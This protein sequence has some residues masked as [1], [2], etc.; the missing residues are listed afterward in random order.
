M[1]IGK[2]SKRV[3]LTGAGWSHNWGARLAAGV[4]QLILDFPDVRN[5]DR[6]SALLRDEQSFE[7][8]LART[9]SPPFVEADH[10]S[11]QRAL[12]EAFISMDRAIASPPNP[13]INIYQVQDL[14]FRFWGQR[15]H[16]VDT[17][18]L[19]TLNQ[20]LFFERYLYNN[21]VY[22]APPPV[23]PAVQ[24]SPGQR[25]FT[26]NVEA[27]SPQFVM[28]PFADPAGQ[29]RLR[30]Q[31]NVIKLHGSFNWRMPN[32]GNVLVVGTEKSRQIADLPLLA[33]YFDIFKMVLYEAERL[34]IIGYGFGDEHV[35]AVIAEAIEKHGLKVFIWDAGP[36]L[37]ERVLAA[38]HGSTIWNG[39]LSTETQR[40]IEVFPPS[41][42]S[43][44]ETE[45]YRR[46]RR[47]FF[48]ETRFWPP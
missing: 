21:H 9:R 14:L 24:P 17:G 3:L 13:K 34:M 40:M 18:Y 48:D 4:W 16:G 45:E 28:H 20:D 15:N 23:L 44:N 11:F 7:F 47:S 35:N 41:S 46:I 43:Q 39:L 12:L 31:M 10:R 30:G 36:S 38:A 29:G 1:D 5:N 6:L 8:A 22:G 42:P 27:Y 19:F 33:W 26:T 32:A 2:F 37:K 25:Y